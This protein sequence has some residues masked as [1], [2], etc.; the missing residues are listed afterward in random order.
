MLKTKY[1]AKKSFAKFEILFGMH[2]KR[3][4][5]SAKKLFAYFSGGDCV[6]G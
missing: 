5:Q 2:T 3:W 6:L 4:K 1:K